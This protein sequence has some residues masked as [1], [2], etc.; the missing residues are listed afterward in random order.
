MKNWVKIENEKIV[1]PPENDTKPGMFN[2]NKNEKWLKEHG[3]FQMTAEELEPYLPKPENPP[4]KYSTLKIIRVLGDE[5]EN[6]RQQLETAGYLD[7][8][9][10]ANYLSADDPVFTAFLAAVPEETKSKLQECLW[11]DY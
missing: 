7:Q 6:Y 5:W 9:F 2:V 11:E 4:E 1:Y 8:F 3:Y 10:A